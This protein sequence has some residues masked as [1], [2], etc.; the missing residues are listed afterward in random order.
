[1]IEITTIVTSAITAVV[2]AY[3]TAKATSYSRDVVGERKEWRDK[4]RELAVD[5][6][7]LMES[8]ETHSPAFHDIIAEFRVRLNPDDSD[9]NQLVD[10]LRECVEVPN[11]LLERK[12]LAQVA[13]LLKHDWERA[14]A[15][16]RLFN[17]RRVNERNMRMLKSSDYM[18]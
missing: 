14:K 16:S 7:R 12:F 9:D 5:A 3:A 4:M 10:T 6:S 2:V 15:E 13:R 11:V 18:C 8:G 1:M 17:Y